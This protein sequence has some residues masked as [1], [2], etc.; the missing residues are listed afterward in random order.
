[1]REFNGSS[2]AIYF[3]ISFSD[4]LIQVDGLI[5]EVESDFLFLFSD[6]VCVN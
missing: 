6:R 4:F 3:P 1:M 5:D 2:Y